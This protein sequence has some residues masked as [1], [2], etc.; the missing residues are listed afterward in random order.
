MV[1]HSQPDTEAILLIGSTAFKKSYEDWDD[2]DVQVYTRHKPKHE[3]YY[4]II[5]DGKG[6]HLLGVRYFALER[7]KNPAV[8][9][10]QQK[11][12]QVLFG[13]EESLRHIFVWRPRKI[14]PVPKKLPRFNEFYEVYFTIMVDLFFMLKRYEARGRPGATKA[15]LCRD[16]VR[17]FARHFYEFYGVESTVG[18]RTRWRKVLGN[19]VRLL[20]ERG[21]VRLCLNKRFVH[22]AITL[23]ESEC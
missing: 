13:S 16:G 4:E 15:R 2:F 12:V 11:D 17:T 22:E 18:D 8:S 19:V 10:L 9:V 7:T 14:E 20:D 21:F 1:L 6:R 5:R 3:L 23:L